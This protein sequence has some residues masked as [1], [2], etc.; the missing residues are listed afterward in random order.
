M[1]HVLCISKGHYCQV[2]NYQVDS[3]L[4]HDLRTGTGKISVLPLQPSRSCNCCPRRVILNCKMANRTWV[5]ACLKLVCK[6]QCCN[7]RRVFRMR[8]VKE[9]MAYNLRNCNHQHNH[10]GKYVDCF[11]L[12]LVQDEV[13]LLEIIIIVKVIAKFSN[14]A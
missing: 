5:L 8:L 11:F 12:V 7:N 2:Q 3:T 4:S 1:L 6:C 13:I 14:D 9:S 10:Y